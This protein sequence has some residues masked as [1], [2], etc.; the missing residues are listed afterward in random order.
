[1]RTAAPVAATAPAM[2]APSGMRISPVPWATVRPELAALA[3]DHEDAAAVGLGHPGRRVVDGPE[4][5][6]EVA[7]GGHGLGHLEEA[8]QLLEAADERGVVHW[9]RR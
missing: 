2:P 8:L 3:V 5:G 1:M 4:Q 9:D 6:A 7:L